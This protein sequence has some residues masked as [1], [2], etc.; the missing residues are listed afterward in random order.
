MLQ[1]VQDTVRVTVL[2]VVPRDELDKVVVQ[3]DTSLGVKDGRVGVTNEILRHNLAQSM[4]KMS[5]LRKVE[6]MGYF[7]LGVAEN[8]LQGTVGGRLDG[9]LD[10]LIAATRCD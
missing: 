4:S 9:F 10:R 1:Q 7:I 5:I 2:V 6:R 8:A 3:A